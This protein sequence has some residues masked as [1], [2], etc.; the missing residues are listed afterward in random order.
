MDDWLVVS[1]WLMLLA[2]SITWQVEGYFL[3]WMFDVLNGKVL[4]SESFFNQF[5]K[6]LPY[7]VIWNYLYYSSLWAVKFSFLVFLRQ[8]GSKAKSHQI[9]WWVVTT[10]T[11]AAW[12]ACVADIDYKCT[13]SDLEYISG[14][15]KAYRMLAT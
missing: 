13:L 12:V 6:F 14:K 3:T 2:F 1:A 15:Y 11:L 4:P 7:I 9:W 10:L 5:T 8:L